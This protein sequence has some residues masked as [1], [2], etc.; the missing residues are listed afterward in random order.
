M[1]GHALAVLAVAAAARAQEQHRDQADPAAH[2]VHHDGTGEIVK[3]LAERSLEPGLHSIMVV[4]GDTF[5]ERVDEADQQETGRKLRVEP[6][7]LGA[8]ARDDG[9]NGP[10]A[11]PP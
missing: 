3:L 5:K 1:R 6:G 2:R 10:G 7:A 9:R 11:G 8:A 4:P